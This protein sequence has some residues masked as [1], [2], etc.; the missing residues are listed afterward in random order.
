MRREFEAGFSLVELLVVVAVTSLARS[1]CLLPAVQSARAAARRASCANNLKQVGLA[2]HN[3][4]QRV[5]VVAAEHDSR[6]RP[7]KRQQCVHGDVALCRAGSASTICTTS[8][9]KTGNVSQPNGRRHLGEDLSVPRQSRRR[10][11]PGRRRPIP[12]QQG[13]LCQGALRQRTGEAVMRAGTRVERHVPPTP[14]KGG[15][16]GDPGVTDFMKNRGAY[17]GVIM[18]VS[19]PEGQVKAK[20]GK[21]LARSVRM[22]DITDGTSFTLAFLEKRDSFGW[23]VGGWGG[24]EF[25][26]HTSPAYD[27]DD[28]LA[29]KVYSG[30]TH[31]KA[32]SALMCDCS[33]RSLSPSQD[34]MTW[35]ALITAPVATSSSSTS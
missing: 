21:P 20:D 27:G 11:R 6:H 2:L 33:V 3:Y 29:R 1:P 23:A 34:R 35:Y 18:T 8:T 31:R 19:S 25:D 4:S 5:G 12:G 15:A 13:D 22:A 17:L 30:S 9:L 28:L 26:V 10:E 24:S 32:R 16:H 7:R 14:P